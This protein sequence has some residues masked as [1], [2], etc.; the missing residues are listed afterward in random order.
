MIIYELTTRNSR[1]HRKAIR[2]MTR[3]PFWVGCM[4]MNPQLAALIEIAYSTIA[5][6]IAVLAA[7]LFMRWWTI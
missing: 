1:I 6:G 5:V 3:E 7:Y 4:P 2:A